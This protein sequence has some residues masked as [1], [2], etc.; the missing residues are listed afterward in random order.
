MVWPTAQFQADT[1][2]AGYFEFNGIPVGCDLTLSP[3]LDAPID[4]GVNILDA[5][6]AG[7][8]H[9]D[10]LPLT[11]PY[12]LLAADV[13]G[14]GSLDNNDDLL[15]AQAAI[16]VIDQFVNTGS[17]K[18]IQQGIT[19]D[20]PDNPWLTLLNP[21]FCLAE[22]QDQ[23]VD[24][25]AIKSGDVHQTAV[26]QFT[27]SDDRKKDD[28]LVL[29]APFTTFEAGQTIE[30]PI[31][32]PDPSTWPAFQFAIAYDQ[33]KL[34][35]VDVQPG[36]IPET[37]LASNSD[38]GL[39]R[40][41]WY[42]PTLINAQ[43]KGEPQEAIRL[44]FETLEAGQTDQAIFLHLEKNANLAVNYD[45]SETDVQLFFYTPRPEPRFYSPTPNPAT[46]LVNLRWELPNAGP[47][48][49]TITDLQGRV[50]KEL[51]VQAPAGPF[52]TS[53]ELP[54]KSPT[55]MLLIRM[56]S[57]SGVITRKVIRRM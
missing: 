38:E 42:E 8:H 9:M 53:I 36:L 4:N 31:T 46:D 27:Q 2:A 24:F 44:V 14:S 26:P 47:V 30:V 3:D 48:Q 33:Q 40:A 49:F 29:T 54:A 6:L 18:F 13:D 56:E 37:L 34:Q 41:G 52:G 32:A 16:G 50:H 55:G 28:D 17:W 23:I 22:D 12:S 39:V 11:S 20:N 15:I 35:L 10:I 19:F 21:G 51:Q 5:L 1:D 57:E 25:T 7:A 45:L 43:G